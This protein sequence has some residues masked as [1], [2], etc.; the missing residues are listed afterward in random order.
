MLGENLG[1]GAEGEILS[2]AYAKSAKSLG[3]KLY[4]RNPKT[5][6]KA[7]LISP[8]YFCCLHGGY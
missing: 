8:V 7:Q 1:E 2:G 3:F 5:P 4:H 6:N